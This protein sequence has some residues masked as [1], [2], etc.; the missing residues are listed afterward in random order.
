MTLMMTIFQLNLYYVT[1]AVK[2]NMFKHEYNPN[3]TAG[4]A[5]AKIALASKLKYV[6]SERKTEVDTWNWYTLEEWLESWT[7]QDGM[8]GELSIEEV[9]LQDNVGI[10][11][12]QVKLYFRLDTK[13][14]FQD[15]ADKYLR[16]RLLALEVT[17]ENDN[18]KKLVPMVCSYKY[19]VPQDFGGVNV[20]ELTFVRAKSV[21]VF[22]KLIVDDIVKVSVDC[23]SRAAYIQTREGVKEGYEMGVSKTD[24]VMSVKDWHLGNMPVMLNGNGRQYIFVRSAAE[25][26]GLYISKPY[27]I[28]CPY[29]G[30]KIEVFDMQVTAVGALKT[31]KVFLKNLAGMNVQ[32]LEVG[33][34]TNLLSVANW[35]D[36]ETTGYESEGEFE[37]L[38]FLIFETTEAIVGTKK[39]FIRDKDKVSTVSDGYLLQIEEIYFEITDV[40]LQKFPNKIIATVQ[41]DN[42]ANYDIEYSLDETTWQTSNI[43]DNLTVTDIFYARLADDTDIVRSFEKADFVNLSDFFEVPSMSF[44]APAMLNQVDYSDIPDFDIPKFSN[45]EYKFKTMLVGP[46]F[47]AQSTVG[48]VLKKG[49]NIIEWGVMITGTERQ[50]P[51]YDPFVYDPDFVSVLDAHER[52]ISITTG[53]A[54]NLSGFSGTAEDVASVD[55]SLYSS[56]SGG[57]NLNIAKFFDGSKSYTDVELVLLDIENG[58]RNLPVADFVNRIIPF[59]KYDL[60]KITGIDR[61]SVV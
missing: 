46:N 22:A 1:G 33:I 56:I 29:L 59:E 19:T 47:R 26:D 32:N 18:V 53:P 57:L 54:L 16:N 31:F 44:D 20:H 36:T 42:V 40:V 38:P 24:N 39:L 5:K 45:G 17:L 52:A 9:V 50:V 12:Y 2:E 21:D 30:A 61:K 15:Y 55:Y 3:R 7:T 8:K 48:N 37:V 10:D 11:K 28:N 4:I 23:T 14:N 60:K 27:F 41:V 49:I 43:F 25:P 13:E 58:I 35:I 6:H 34:G 51:T